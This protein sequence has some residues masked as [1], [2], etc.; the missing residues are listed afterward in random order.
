MNKMIAVVAACALLAGC[1]KPI[2]VDG[3][4]YPTY[5]LFNQN[6]DKSERMCYELSVGNVVWS[7]ILIETI[8][9]PFYFVGFSLFNPVGPRNAKGECG[10]DAT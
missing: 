9:A 2:T 5:G 1:G 10:I 6:S 7:I 4:H 8:I 3:K